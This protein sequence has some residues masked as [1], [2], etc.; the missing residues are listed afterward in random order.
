[1][2]AVQFIPDKTVCQFSATIYDTK[3]RNGRSRKY[4][5]ISHQT[6]E[7]NQFYRKQICFLQEKLIHRK[8]N[9]L[10][11]SDKRT[12]RYET[13]KRRKLIIK[14]SECDPRRE[15]GRLLMSPPCLES[16]GCQFLP[17]VYTSFRVLLPSPVAFSVLSVSALDQFFPKPPFT[18]M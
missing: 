9:C 2:N 11:Q 16:Q 8:M 7:S 15:A 13:R 3:K 18:V 1:M 6:A 10:Q 5:K 17:R 12:D 14:W 4:K